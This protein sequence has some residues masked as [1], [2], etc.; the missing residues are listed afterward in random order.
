MTL[1]NTRRA[2]NPHGYQKEAIR[3]I[4]GHPRCLLSLDMG[5]GKTAITLFTLKRML[6][7]DFSVTRVLVIAPK[8][9]AEFTWPE[10]AAKWD[11]AEGLTMETAIG[12]EA[13]RRRAVESHA[14]IVTINRENVAWL[15]REYGKRW[16]FDAIVVDES[17]SFKSYSSQRFKALR[18][19]TPRVSVLILLSGTPMPRSIED[20]FPQIGLIDQGQRLGRSMTAFRQKFEYPGRRN[21]MIIYEWLPN[22]GAKE[23][24]YRLISDIALSMQAKDLLD[25]PPVTVI[26]HKFEL[27]PAQMKEYRNFAKEAVLQLEEKAIVGENAGTLSGKLIQYAAGAVYDDEKNWHVVHDHKID[28]LYDLIEDSEEP[29]IIFYW[30]KSDLARLQKALAGY[31]PRVLRNLDDIWDWNAGKIRLLLVHPASAGHGLNLQ[32]GGHTIIW[33][34]LTWS[35]ELYQQAN[36]RLHRQGQIEPVRIHRIIA[37]GT[38]EETLIA[39]LEDKDADQSALLEAIKAHLKEVTE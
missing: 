14:D 29:M 26:D 16:P 15:V 25:L 34:S 27:T 8:H 12:P 31:H 30:F 17:S 22:P 33:F 6:Y 21:G 7:E 2:F 37:K 18:K 1:H 4:E 19:V 20:L 32:Y 35:L 10:E 5:L 28:V 23:E 39:S 3:F 38:V 36:A 9:V 24:I 13:K 11:F